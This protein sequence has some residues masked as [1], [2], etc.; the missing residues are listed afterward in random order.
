MWSATALVV[1]NMIG[2]GIFTT[3]TAGTGQRVHRASADSRRDAG[4]IAPVL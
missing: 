1:S 4:L 3:T 2:T